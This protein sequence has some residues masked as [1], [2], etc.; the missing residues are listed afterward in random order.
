ME[1]ASRYLAYA[2]NPGRG[3]F[4]IEQ[5][6]APPAPQPVVPGVVP[7]ANR[8]TR[9]FGWIGVLSLAVG[10]A[11]AYHGYKRTQSVGWAV[12]WGLG[13]GAVWPIMLPIALAQGFGRPE[14]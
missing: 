6:I 9:S 7:S 5:S 14:R 3:G 4:G 8:P 13:G 2:T 12:A 10:S 11:L 1:D